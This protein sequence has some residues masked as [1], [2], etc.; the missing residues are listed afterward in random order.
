ME[1]IQQDDK[2]CHLLVDYEA[3]AEIIGMMEFVHDL[4]MSR[5]ARVAS[6]RTVFLFLY[7]TIGQMTGGEDDQS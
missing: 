3:R 6:D 7:S 4:K 2:L 1:Q 5:P